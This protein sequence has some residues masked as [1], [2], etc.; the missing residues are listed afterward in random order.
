ME[1]VI[2]GNLVRA[3]D[4]QGY[5]A[6]VVGKGGIAAQAKLLEPSSL[7]HLVNAAAVWKVASVLVAQKHIHDINSKLAEIS[8]QIN[9]VSAFQKQSRR[10][11]IEGQIDNFSQVYQVVKAGEL[12]A[13]PHAEFNA[14]E[15]GLLSCEQAP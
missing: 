3:S 6:F 1:V 5:R 8:V 12:P 10:A 7:S 14:C 13:I 2:K 4:G 11:T 9:Q 15:L